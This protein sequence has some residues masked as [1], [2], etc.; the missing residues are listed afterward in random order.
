[1]SLITVAYI[2]LIVGGLSDFMTTRTPKIEKT[3]YS[4]VLFVTAFI[5]T[6]KYYYGPDIWSYVPYYDRV[7]TLP[8][9]LRGET[10]AIA[11]YRFEFGYGV[12]CSIFK[13]LGLSFWTMTA[14]IQILYFYSIHVL[15]K[16]IEHKRTFALMIVIILDA[17]INYT[18]YRQCL[19]VS[20]FYLM[21]DAMYNRQNSKSALYLILSLLFHRSALFI[22]AAT[23][24]TLHIKKTKYSQSTFI[25]FVLLLSIILFL[26]ISNILTTTVNSL[27]LDEETKKSLVL[28]L[29]LGRQDQ[30]IFIVYFM[31]LLTIEYFNRFVPSKAQRIEGAIILGIFITIAMYQYFFLLNR[32]RPYFTVLIVVYTFTSI[33]QYFGQ[34][35]I[36]HRYDKLL[37]DVAALIIFSYAMR[38]TYKVADYNNRTERT[39]NYSTIFSLLNADKETIVK[40]QME[41]AEIYWDKYYMSDNENKIEE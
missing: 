31:A 4:I 16:H 21:I 22:A 40:R 11:D 15:L 28:H 14:A 7:P 5:F 12:F 30:V 17:S 33:Q 37:R 10:D 35:K 39:Y 41:L 26:P 3:I 36:R 6:I 38:Y 20:F 8:Q 18:A 13:T 27:T 9:L 19:S 34:D 24:L 25:I 32:V 29:S 2:I 23:I 1:M